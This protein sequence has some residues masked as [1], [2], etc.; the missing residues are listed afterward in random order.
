LSGVAATGVLLARDDGDDD[1]FSAGSRSRSLDRSRDMTTAN[2]SNSRDRSRDRTGD[3]V[4]AETAEL[5]AACLAYESSQRP[6]A[7][8]VTQELER[9][10]AEQPRRPVLSRFRIRPRL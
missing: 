2:R 1:D 8:E 10:V 6:A 3:G 7:A 9:L 4:G 5:I